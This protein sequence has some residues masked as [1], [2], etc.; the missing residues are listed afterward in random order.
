MK[1]KENQYIPITNDHMFKTVF[2]DEHLLKQLLERILP[3]VRIRTLGVTIKEFAIEH[4]DDTHG[5]RLDVYAENSTQMFSTEMQNR[6]AKYPSKRARYSADMMDT[7]SLPA[8]APYHA[9][10]DCYV[11]IITPQDPFR[12]GRMVYVI[13]ARIRGSRRTVRE[14][15]TVI[16]VNCSGT[17]GQEKYAKLVPF[18]RYVMGQK[19]DDAFVNEIDEN[20]QKYN[21]SRDWRRR[22]MEWEQYRLE[23][24]EQGEERGEK[25]GIRIGKKQGEKRGIRI[26]KKQ[27]IRRAVKAQCK[28]LMTLGL[29]KEQAI[30]YVRKDYPEVSVKKI[31]KI[32]G[33]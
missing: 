27:G 3:D 16:Y 28:C 5:I 21:H 26:G 14:G 8:G 2:S 9:L 17:K 25:R 12:E 22:H 29:N 31:Q 32:I 30:Q 7:N 4:P 10:K 1:R 13:E 11:I 15:R 20:V 19:K 18:C 24:I 23:L 33:A 6:I